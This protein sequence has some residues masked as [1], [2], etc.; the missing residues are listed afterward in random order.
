MSEIEKRV[1]CDYCDEWV[2]DEEHKRLSCDE[3]KEEI[4]EKNRIYI[5]EV[6]KNI[7]G[8]CY[9]E[10]YDDLGYILC[11][12]CGCAYLSEEDFRKCSS[13]EQ[14]DCDWERVCLKCVKRDDDEDYFRCYHCGDWSC[15][16]HREMDYDYLNECG[17]A[18]EVLEWC[19]NC[20]RLKDRS[21]GYRR[22]KSKI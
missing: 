6:D 3:C 4:C 10:D 8:D 13:K 15:Y 11:K 5:K 17:N 14:D 19:S 9:F 22:K 16:D 1:K 20:Y 12:Y 2:L 18:Y 21:N 7:C